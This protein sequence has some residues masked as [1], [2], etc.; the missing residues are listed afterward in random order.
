[1]LCPFLLVSTDS[2]VPV[3]RA[4]PGAG[5]GETGLKSGMESLLLVFSSIVESGLFVDVSF[6]PE[7]AQEA[8]AKN[9]TIM[10]K[11]GVKPIRCTLTKI[12]V[13]YFAI[14]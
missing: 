9:S 10:K 6:S 2:T 1:M 13:H 12:G 8:A 11:W 7:E 3:T 14:I 5:A 4:V